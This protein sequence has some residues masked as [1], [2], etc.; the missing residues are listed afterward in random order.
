[1]ERRDGNACMRERQMP[2]RCDGGRHRTL[3]DLRRTKHPAN[4]IHAEAVAL[5]EARDRHHVSSNLAC[6]AHED[7]ALRR[8]TLQ[9]RVSD[10]GRIDL[11]DQHIRP[12]CFG[13]ACELANGLG[14]R[15]K[16]GW[17]VERCDDDRPCF[18]GDQR[19]N[20]LRLYAE[21]LAREAL[22]AS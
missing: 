10:E 3:D 13:D 12:L 7:P 15:S 1:R 14:R 9:W 8:V 21:G 19:R 22:K 16:A 20:A 17:I 18:W 2:K 4:A 6:T 11:V 5:R